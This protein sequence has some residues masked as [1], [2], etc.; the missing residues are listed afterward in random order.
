MTWVLSIRCYRNVIIWEDYIWKYIIIVIKIF[1]LSKFITSYG[2][3][4]FNFR[5][6]VVGYILFI[7]VIIEF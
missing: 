6:I 1:I 2:D 7:F 3:F 5:V 4:G